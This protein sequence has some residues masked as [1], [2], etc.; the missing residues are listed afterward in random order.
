VR[1]KYYDLEE[2]VYSDD[3]SALMDMAMAELQ[4]AGLIE[5]Y[6][7]ST[8]GAQNMETFRV[9]LLT[10]HISSCMDERPAISA[11]QTLARNC[12]LH[13]RWI[14]RWD[15]KINRDEIIDLY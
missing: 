5:G 6:V 11:M 7:T 1:S 12:A 2:V 13:L 8:G 14:V 15:V 3:G 9:F 4:N 10:V